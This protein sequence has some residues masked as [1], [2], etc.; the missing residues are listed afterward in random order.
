M[1][2]T[3]EVTHLQTLLRAV[4]RAPHRRIDHHPLMAPLLDAELSLEHYGLV[5]EFF[6]EFYRRLQPVLEIQLGRTHYSFSDRT[7]WLRADLLALEQRGYERSHF[8]DER[9]FPFPVTDVPTL[10]GLLYVIEGSTLGGQV[11]AR[12]VQ[13][14]LGVSVLH[15][16]RFFYGYGEQ[17][18]QHWQ[19]FWDFANSMTQPDDE[20]VMA[21][22]AVATFDALADGLDLV[23]MNYSLCSSELPT[24]GVARG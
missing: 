13:Q 20:L 23:W 19:D 10:I 18:E 22:A 16:G 6:A 15:G 9:L 8:S 17:T 5:L 4:T 12:Q 1:S 21:E 11:I 14:S 24:I 3:A 7:A 2:F